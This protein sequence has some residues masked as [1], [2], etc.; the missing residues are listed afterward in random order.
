MTFRR[1]VAEAL[2]RPR[3]R[4]AVAFAAFALVMFAG[5]VTAHAAAESGFRFSRAEGGDSEA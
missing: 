4:L 5:F 1:T 3:V 2:A